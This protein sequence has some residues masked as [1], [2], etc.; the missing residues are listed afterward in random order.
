MIIN[1]EEAKTHLKI[2]FDSDDKYIELL[3]KASEEFIYNS[4]GKNFNEQNSLAKIAS[5][6]IVSDLYENRTMSTDKMNENIRSI[7]NM[8]LVQ[9][10]ISSR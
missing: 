8:I 2:D 7:V 9:L 4:T 6:F 1:L 10:S 3:I 5:L